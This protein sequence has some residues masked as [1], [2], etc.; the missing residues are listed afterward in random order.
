M[1]D[2][3]RAA[4]RDLLSTSI[5]ELSASLLALA[6]LLL[7]VRRSLWCWPCAFI[8]TAIYLVLT[9]RAGLVMQ[10]LLQVFYL[11]M[12]VYGF[13]EWRRGRWRD[14][15]MAIVHWSW[16]RHLIVISTVV[17]VSIVN[18]WLLGYVKGAQAPLLD[19][20]VTWGSVITTWMVTQRIIE[21]WLYWVV[22]DGVAAYLYFDQGFNAFGLLFVVYI[23][24]VIHGY[25]VWLK[26]QRRQLAL[27]MAAEASSGSA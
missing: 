18:A 26:Q 13:I 7:A 27:P 10:T 23:G 16:L 8:S 9:A 15:E 20:L 22:V 12:A 1:I 3:L 6:Y 24:I 4:A 19:S 25:F 11:A 17:L 2:L 21:N 14:G 5:W